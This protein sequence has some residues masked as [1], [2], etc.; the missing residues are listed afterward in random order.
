M[1]QHADGFLNLVTEAKKHINELLPQELK[2]KLD[3]HE[4]MHLIDVREDN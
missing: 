4:S 1:K 3:A 2:Q